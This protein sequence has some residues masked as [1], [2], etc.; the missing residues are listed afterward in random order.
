M[1]AS[2]LW[3]GAI[4]AQIGPGTGMRPP[5]RAS[6]QVL[7]YS[8]DL[9]EVESPDCARRGSRPAAAYS[10][11]ASTPP[12]SPLLTATTGQLTFARF[13]AAIGAWKAVIQL[14]TAANEAL[15]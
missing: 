10:P 8:E 5:S 9:T 14:L 3:G 11:A 4:W 15:L 6:A 2:D 7:A 1:A 13:A 12:S